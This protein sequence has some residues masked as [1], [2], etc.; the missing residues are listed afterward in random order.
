MSSSRLRVGILGAG[1]WARFAHIPG[2]QRDPRAEVV[3][4]A[5]VDPDAA[6]DV[7]REFGIPEATADWQA[8]VARD[9][10]D[11]IDVV[12]PSHTHFE[13]SRAAIEAG[14]HVLC[15]KPVAYDERDTLALPETAP[16]RG[17]ELGGGGG[18]GPGFV[19]SD[20]RAV[21]ALARGR[22]ADGVETHALFLRYRWWAAVV[23]R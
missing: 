23:A 21:R 15:E 18:E 2:W 8:L 4:I 5:D 17:I 13:L 9:D 3:A 7:A 16:E 10:L 11:V 6:H 20:D 14:K 22:A 19:Q 1:A 12:T